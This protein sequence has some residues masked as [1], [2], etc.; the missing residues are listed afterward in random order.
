M[1][2]LFFLLYLPGR[3]LSSPEIRFPA[4]AGWAAQSLPGLFAALAPG[5]AGLR[6]KNAF[7][8]AWFVV[9]WSTDVSTFFDVTIRERQ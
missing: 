8:A 9:Q 1:V 7:Q 6:R 4:L 2:V 5:F 3:G